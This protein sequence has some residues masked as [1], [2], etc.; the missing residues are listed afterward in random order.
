MAIK[1]DN[2]PKMEQ[3][4]FCFPVWALVIRHTHSEQY[5]SSKFSSAFNKLKHPYDFLLCLIRSA[6]V[7]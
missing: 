4:G 3:K 5:L 1:A 7:A 6:C 2:T